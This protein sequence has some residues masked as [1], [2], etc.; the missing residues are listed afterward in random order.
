MHLVSPFDGR[1]YSS[2]VS[3][4]AGLRRSPRCH[5]PEAPRRLVGRS[6]LFVL[7]V[8]IPEVRSR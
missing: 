5:A 6:W 1:P 4:G 2:S 3:A 7:E 8:I